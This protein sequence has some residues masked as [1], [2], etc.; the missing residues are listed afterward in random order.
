MPN[1]LRPVYEFVASGGRASHR[2]SSIFLQGGY[3]RRPVH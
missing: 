2:L 1:R 3:G